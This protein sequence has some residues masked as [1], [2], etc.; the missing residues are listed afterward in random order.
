M[1]TFKHREK[2]RKIDASNYRFAQVTEELM[3]HNDLANS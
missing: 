2:K 1:H 3:I